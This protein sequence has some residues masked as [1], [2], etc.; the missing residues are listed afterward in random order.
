MDIWDAMSGVVVPPSRVDEEAS[1]TGLFFP[2]C[3]CGWLSDSKVIA[4][5]PTFSASAPKVQLELW[6]Q[7]DYCSSPEH[8]VAEVA[9]LLSVPM[10]A[11]PLPLKLSR[12]GKDQREVEVAG[13]ASPTSVVVTVEVPLPCTKQLLPPSHLSPA[14]RDQ[15]VDFAYIGYFS[16][17]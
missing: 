2:L 7:S 14:Q 17:W 8:S 9:P 16:Q 11:P 5:Q 10:K 4:P 6:E 13:E 12:A 1:C 3:Y 15:D